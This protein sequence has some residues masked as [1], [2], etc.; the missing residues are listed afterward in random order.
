MSKGKT[1]IPGSRKKPVRW[2]RS[3]I[4][5]AALLGVLLAAFCIW[6][7]IWVQRLHFD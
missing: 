3:E 7:V 5:H 4:L 6:L 1:L 2:K